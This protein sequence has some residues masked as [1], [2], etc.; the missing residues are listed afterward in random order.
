MK[1]LFPLSSWLS[2]AAHTFQDSDILKPGMKY[3]LQSQLLGDRS[4]KISVIASSA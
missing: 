1:T 3:R 2:Y 4:R